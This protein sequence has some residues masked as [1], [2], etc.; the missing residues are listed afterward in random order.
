[1]PD[2]PPSRHAAPLAIIAVVIGAITAGVFLLIDWLPDQ[3]SKQAER[4]DPLLWFVIISCGVIFTIVMTFLLYSI[5]RF[6]A[7]EGDEEDGPPIHGN[8]KLEIAWTIVPTLL[9]A[10]MAVWAYMVLTDNEAL[11]EDRMIVNVTA[12]QF[13]W[14]FTYPDAGIESGDLRIPVDRQVE[15]KM[16]AVDVIHDLYVPEFRVKQD[17]VPG[18]ITKLV[19]DPTK[20]GKYPIICAELCGLGHNTMRASVY[21]MP[22]A[23]Y[24]KWLQ[25]SKEQVA[26][27]GRPAS[28][29]AAGGAD[30]AG[31]RPAGAADQPTGDA[32]ASQ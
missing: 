14:T 30:A 32:A 12:E 2:V 15:L 17:V 31:T 18:V 19:V 6:K 26:A 29:P 28:P 8:T 25:T 16:T 3:A 22:Q 11:A 7:K 21:V 23:Q 9:L 10:V 4:V 13:A 27:A 5:F 20:V 1:L 24:D